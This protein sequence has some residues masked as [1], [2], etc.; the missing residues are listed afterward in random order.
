TNASQ[1]AIDAALP[2][3]YDRL[4][5]AIGGQE[6]VSG[7]VD[8]QED[9]NVRDALREVG[10]GAEELAALRSEDER[11]DVHPLTERGEPLQEHVLVP[12]RDRRRDACL[13]VATAARDQPQLRRDLCDA[14]PAGTV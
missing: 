14:A 4:G 8:A 13:H 10:D 3:S 1:S 2:P 6:A 11:G 12:H 9:A 7:L 5:A